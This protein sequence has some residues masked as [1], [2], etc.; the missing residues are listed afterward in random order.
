MKTGKSGTIGS[1]L[2]LGVG[3]LE[4]SSSYSWE[5]K[6]TLSCLPC[7]HHTLP[8]P[9][10]SL[11]FPAWP[12]EAFRLTAL[13]EREGTRCLGANAV[14]WAVSGVQ[15]QSCVQLLFPLISR[16]MFFCTSQ[17]WLGL[18]YSMAR[19]CVFRPVIYILHDETH[20]GMAPLPPPSLSTSSPHLLH[21]DHH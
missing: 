14:L 8:C 10:D 2:A 13:T 1:A 12:L 17:Q 19:T 16:P 18:H 20:L 9:R 15:R 5:E 3:L 4:L 11:A 6:V 7:P 21:C